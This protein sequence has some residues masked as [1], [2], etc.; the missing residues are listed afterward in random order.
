MLNLFSLNQIYNFIMLPIRLLGFLNYF[1]LICDII[2]ALH[3]PFSFLFDLIT[4]WL[5]ACLNWTINFDFNNA[6]NGLQPIMFTNH[7]LLNNVCMHNETLGI[8]EMVMKFSSNSHGISKCWSSS[9]NVASSPISMLFWWCCDFSMQI[10]NVTSMNCNVGGSDEL[11]WRFCYCDAYN[12]D[13]HV[14]CYNKLGEH[15]M[16]TCFSLLEM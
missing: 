14:S 15:F 11:Q 16:M 8:N 13:D 12:G 6:Y 9:L 10:V 7:F 1:H 2:R 3:F 5:L 4:F